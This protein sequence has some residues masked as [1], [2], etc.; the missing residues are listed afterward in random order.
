MNAHTKRLA[1]IAAVL[2]IIAVVAVVFFVREINK[3]SVHLSEQ[4]AAIEIDRAQQAVFN[5]IKRTN[6][7][8]AET[9]QELQSYY[10][11]SQSD[12]IDFLN[13]IESQAAI[14][15]VELL[16]NLPTEVVEDGTTYL[17]VSYVFLGSL[18]RLENFVKQLEN[19]P[20]VSQLESLSLVQ[21]TGSIWEAKVE[22]TVNVLNYETQ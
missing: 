15:G 9:R 6:V 22:I 12:S 1:V 3:Q 11:L 10:L 5:R 17:S 7:E 16:T 8:T 21:Q 14:S 13:F 19:I 2:F 18:N 20:Y 4:I